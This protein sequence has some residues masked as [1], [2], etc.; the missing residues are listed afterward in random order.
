LSRFKIAKRGD[1]WSI[2]DKV[3]N[4]TESKCQV[5]LPMNEDKLVQYIDPYLIQEQEI[6]DMSYFFFYA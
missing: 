6:L 3:K 1:S 5:L 4:E 2:E